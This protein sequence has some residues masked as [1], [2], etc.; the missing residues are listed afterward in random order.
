MDAIAMVIAAG[1]IPFK[2]KPS[3]II[4][5]P[6]GWGWLQVDDVSWKGM[7]IVTR[8]VQKI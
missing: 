5:L 3:P 8:L 1:G 4:S 2:R 6:P 7:L